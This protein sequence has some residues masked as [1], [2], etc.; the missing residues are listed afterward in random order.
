MRTTILTLTLLACAPAAFAQLTQDQ[1]LADFRY[2]AALYEKNYA[3]YEWKK[4]VF[5]FDMLNVQPWLERVSKTKDDLE[6]YDLC[7]EYVASLQDTHDAFSLPSTFVA[8]LGFSVDL[9]DGKVLIENISRTALPAAKYPFAVGDELVSVDGKDSETLL[10]EFSRYAVQSNPRSTRRLAAARIVT[11]PQSRMPRAAEL[12][13][14]ATVVIRRMSGELE[15]YTLPWIKSGLPMQAGPVLSPRFRLPGRPQIPNEAPAPEY[16]RPLLELQHSGVEKTE[17]LLNYGARNPY[18]DL[19]AGFVVRQGRLS[20][21]FFVSGTFRSGPY[22]I[23]YIRIPNYAP[24]S[25]TTALQVF[26]AE[27]EYFQQNTDGLVVDQ[28]R[29]TGGNL[30]FGENIASRLIPYPFETTGFVMRPFWS[31]VNSFYNSWQSAKSAGAE[32]WIVD[33]YEVLFNQVYQAYTENRG[34]TGPLPLCGPSMVKLPPTNLAGAVTSY[35]KPLVMLIDEFSTSTADSVPNMLQG[36]GRG[37]LLGMRTNGAGGNNVSFDAGA[38]SEGATGM[39]IA[40]QTRKAPV[41]TPEYPESIYIENAGVRPD[42]ELDYM[43]RENLLQR[44]KPFVE[45]FTAVIVEE[46]RKAK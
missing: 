36:A 45:A 22:T 12:G 40:M 33:T 35:N 32:S 7:I 46:I 3:A 23:G 44:G 10:A 34:L 14:T 26:D 25:T 6:F 39:T 8:S 41:K 17:G 21:D 43:T 1:K 28:T 42:I 19:P 20:S 9:Y 30:C 27:I 37:V 16:L 24:A 31:R 13:D 5:G 2:L 11:R 4:A 18:Y 38:Y 29:N 15:T